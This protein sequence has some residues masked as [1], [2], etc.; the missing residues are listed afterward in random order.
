MTRRIRKLAG[1]ATLLTGFALVTPALADGHGGGGWHGGGHGGGYVYGHGGGYGLG[2]P[3]VGLAA[4]II[5]VPFVLAAS[6]LQPSPVYAQQPPAYIQPPARYYPQPE[7]TYNYGPPQVYYQ[8]EPAPAYYPRQLAMAQA[9]A[10]VEQ[11]AQV[12]VPP[13]PAPSYSQQAPASKY[14]N[15]WYYC[16]KPT[17]YYPYVRQCPTGWQKVSPTPPQ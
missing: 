9:P 16:N 8:P 17:G 12:Y 7:P 10:Y 11:S 3:V 15:W 13:P 14:N 6:L 4:A 2:A 5:T 1:I